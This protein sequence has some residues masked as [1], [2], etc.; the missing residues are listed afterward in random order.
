MIKTKL[1]VLA[2]SAFAVAVM[3]IGFSSAPAVAEETR[4]AGRAVA[5]EDKPIPLHLRTSKRKQF[6]WSYAP[7]TDPIWHKYRHP[8]Q[9][10]GLDWDKDGW[11]DDITEEKVLR[12]LYAQDIFRRQYVVNKKHRDLAV[13]EVGPAFYKLSDHDRRR[14]LKLVA[15]YFNFLESGLPSFDVTDWRTREK[16]GEYNH[17]GFQP[18]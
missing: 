1:T 4:T 18:Y 10:R 8:V 6:N 12:A 11:P 7:A 17:K 14:S 9:W 2:F 5:G 16:I 15:D 3:M 13:L